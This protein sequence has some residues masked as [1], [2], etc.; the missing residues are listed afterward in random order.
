[1]KIDLVDIKKRFETDDKINPSYF[2]QDE[3]YSENETLEEEMLEA[4]EDSLQEPSVMGYFV[5]IPGKEP[6]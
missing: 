3:K 1:M 4:S 5:T 2:E 6:R